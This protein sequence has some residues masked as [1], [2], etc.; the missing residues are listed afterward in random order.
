MFSIKKAVYRDPKIDYM[1]E[2]AKKNLRRWIEIAVKDPNWQIQAM[3][4][5]TGEVLQNH[6]FGQAQWIYG[7]R[8]LCTCSM[9]LLN[10]VFVTI[11]FF[12]HNNERVEL[13]SR[14]G[15]VCARNRVS[16]MGN[17]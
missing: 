4:R 8:S 7:T 16:F 12:F 11:S 3:N 15:I 2:S 1:A 17:Y 10:K 5:E 14:G 6:D 9:N 13:S